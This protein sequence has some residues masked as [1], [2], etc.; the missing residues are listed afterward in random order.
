MFCII[1]FRFRFES[2]LG[3]VND[4]C[5]A[6]NTIAWQQPGDGRVVLN[7]DGSAL[8][9]L[10]KAGFRGLVRNNHEDF[11]WGFYGSVG[12]SDILR[13]KMLALL[14]GLT[15]CWEEGY[16]L[17]VCYSDSM[18]TVRLVHGGVPVHHREANEIKLIQRLMSRTWQVQLH[19]RWREGNYY[20]DYLAKIGAHS[21]E[22]LVRL[23]APPTG[24]STLLL[25]DTM[26]VC[27][28]RG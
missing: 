12:V 20:A 16:P 8:T 2:E 23:D 10:G 21:D 18:E 24:M 3:E 4:L 6:G 9:N 26:G 7:V 13:A 11:L 25:A 19:H 17:A 28:P 1:L 15:L 27:F 22:S 5:D 14:H